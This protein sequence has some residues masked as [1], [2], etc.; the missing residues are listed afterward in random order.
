MRVQFL[1]FAAKRLNRIINLVKHSQT[2]SNNYLRLLLC[3]RMSII[4]QRIHHSMHKANSAC[5]EASTT[6]EQSGEFLT[7]GDITNVHRASRRPA[8][9]KNILNICMFAVPSHCRTVSQKNRAA[10]KYNMMLQ[11][12]HRWI[13]AKCLSKGRNIDDDKWLLDRS[14]QQLQHNSTRRLWYSSTVYLAL[15]FNRHTT[16][17]QCKL[18]SLVHRE[19][20]WTARNSKQFSKYTRFRFVVSI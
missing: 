5:C 15:S 18:C 11:C 4:S 3:M 17:H 2:N 16:E 6:P 20:Y 7:N 13:I 12:D 19:S 14:M 1:P 8:F 10:Q 9:M